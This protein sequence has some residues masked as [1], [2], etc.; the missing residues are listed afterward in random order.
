VIF[1]G[2]LM[3]EEPDA[4]ASDRAGRPAFLFAAEKVFFK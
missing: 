2:E 3:G 1:R 4:L